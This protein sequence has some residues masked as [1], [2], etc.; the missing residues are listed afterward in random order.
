[1]G[2]PCGDCQVGP[3]VGYAKRTEVNVARP[4]TVDLIV[5]NHTAEDVED[6]LAGEDEETARRA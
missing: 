6:H 3:A 4:G 5:L 2:A 1:L